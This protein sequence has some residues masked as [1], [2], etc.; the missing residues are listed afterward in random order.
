ME[1]FNNEKYYFYIIK[2][3]L[4]PLKNYNLLLPLH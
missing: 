3:T 1:I 2:V 4:K